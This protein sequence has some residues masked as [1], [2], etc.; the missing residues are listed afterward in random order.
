VA[1]TESTKIA[2]IRRLTLA[3]DRRLSAL[4][5]RKKELER[6]H[7]ELVESIGKA[8][9]RLS[10]KS[11]VDAFLESL[12]SSIHSKVVSTY[13]EM[14]TAIVQD[15]LPQNVEIGLDLYTERGLPAMDV[16]ARVN[17]HPL[18]IMESQG[19]ALTN[20]VGLGLRSIAAVRSG[21]R[22]F[23]L[24]DESDCWIKPDRIPA[25][26][27]VVKQMSERLGFQAV[28]VSHH[29]VGLFAEGISV[30]EL[31]GDPNIGVEEVLPLPGF[32]QWPNSE[33]PGIRGIRLHNF[34][35]FR[36]AFIPLAPGVTAIIGE[37]NLGKSRI[38]R[39]MRTAFYDREA[40]DED[41][42]HGETCAEV[43]FMLENERTLYWSRDSKRKP[44]TLWK[45][46]EADGSVAVVDG[47]TCIEGATNQK[48]PQWVSKAVGIAR[49]EDLDIQLAH[50]KLPVFLLDK[51][52]TQRASVLSVG[53]ESNRLKNMIVKHKE[54]ASRDQQM[55]KQGETELSSIRH[56]LALLERTE[57]LS[58]HMETL[59]GRID[60]TFASTTS[61][62][63]A[64][65]L[66]E[67]LS[68]TLHNLHKVSLQSSVLSSIPDLPAH[69]TSNI[70]K[71]SQGIS[72]GLT[73][74]NAQ[75]TFQRATLKQ[76]LFNRTPI[77]PENLEER[78]TAL[79]KGRISSAILSKTIT[80]FNQ[81]R[82]RLDIL[83]NI[84]E[85]PDTLPSIGNVTQTIE[86][87]SSSETELAKTTRQRDEAREGEIK[88][89]L[90]LSDVI[91][92]L[93]NICPLCGTHGI[94]HEH[95]LAASE[96]T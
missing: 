75:K 93:G 4:V 9:W 56:R 71:T 83:A 46:T 12:Q 24:L 36:D 20:V 66:A 90:D 51:P 87:I 35:S 37:N 22:P 30:V 77:L 15:V 49:I 2:E 29:D 76:A 68:Q 13:G 89:A 27:K 78:I 44:P 60:K 81:A 1:S 3:A 25:F 82:K 73:L 54:R 45:L 59:S 32:G 50:Q 52:A 55:A 94:K 58:F 84:P 17:G 92:E 74:V 53:R 11:A 61:L 23:V 47:S 14:L 69:L 26:Y 21:L 28:I 70:T 33:M 95:I 41:I 18:N 8:K 88:S 57:A 65:F 39:A 91:D 72:I 85:A 19:G 62:E 43:E 7:Q 42:R 86:Q 38:T 79:T 63:K 96:G 48:V 16:M 67:S 10:R 31:K 5:G 80:D 6:R 64:K 40:A 34:A